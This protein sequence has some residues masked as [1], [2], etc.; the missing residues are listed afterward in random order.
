MKEGLEL[1]LCKIL[2]MI[3]VFCSAPTS[4]LRM[5]RKRIEKNCKVKVDCNG[6]A[7]RI[8]RTFAGFDSPLDMVAVVDDDKLNC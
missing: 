2:K 1:E 5:H 4:F 8:A 3:D 7:E 6:A